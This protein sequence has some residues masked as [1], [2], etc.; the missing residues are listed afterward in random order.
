MPSAANFPEPLP[1]DFSGIP[2]APKDRCFVASSIIACS[3]IKDTV[4]TD[5]M[6]GD[7]TGSLMPASFHAWSDSSRFSLAHNAATVR[8]VKLFF[9]HQPSM[10][11]GLPQ[12]TLSASSSPIIPGSV[13]HYTG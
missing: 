12:F 9:Y 5:G 8:Q 11:I 1:G 3:S 2:T 10:G 6:V 4:L 7:E 13:S